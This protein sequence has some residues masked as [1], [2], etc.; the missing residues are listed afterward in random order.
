MIVKF[1]SWK[2]CA[3]VYKNRKSLVDQ[4]IYLD[5]TTRRFTLLKLAVTRVKDNSK[6]FP[7]V[8]VACV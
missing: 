5:L 8:I 6:V 7:T 3:L 4:K 2:A 1:S